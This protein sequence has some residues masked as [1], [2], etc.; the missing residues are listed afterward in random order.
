M[1]SLYIPSSKRTPEISFNTNGD[2]SIT[3]VSI[4]ENVNSFYQPAFDWIDKLSSNCP[5]KISIHIDF[6]YLNTSSTS[7]VLRLLKKIV[8]LPINKIDL[9]VIWKHESDD[10]DMKEQG[11]ILQNLIDHPFKFENKPAF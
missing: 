8:S 4:P 1:V 2:L 9:E 11:V 5:Q 10:E 3:G 6:E 7:M